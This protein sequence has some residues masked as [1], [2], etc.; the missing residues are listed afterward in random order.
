[1][2]ALPEELAELYRGLEDTLL[3]EICSRLRI[4]DQLNEV[5]V[6]DIRALRSHGIPLEDIKKAIAQ[7][8][9]ISMK[10]LDKLFDD[11]VARNQAYYTEL[12]DLAHVT[13]PE[14]L[15][16][17]AAIY[18]IYEQ[19]R[20]ELR[21]I[22]RSMGFMVRDGRGWRRLTPAKSYQW[23]L[24][25]AVM[26]VESGAISYNQA[27]SRAVKELAGGGLKIV[28]FESGVH[29]QI[30]SHARTCVM[31][32]VNQLNQKYREQSMDYLGTDL[33]EVT[34]HIGARNTGSGYFNHESWQGG[35]YHWRKYGSK[36]RGKY[37]DF[38]EECGMGQGGGIGGW[39]CRHSYWPYLDGIME[40]THSKAELESMKAE[41]HKVTFEGKE[42]DGYTSTQQQ[43]RIEREIR[44]QKR[45]RDACKATG[46][47]EDTQAANIRLNRLNEKYR[48]FSKAAGLPEQRERTK[49]LYA[50]DASKAKAA[51]LKLKRDAEAPIREAIK[52][53]DYP[54]AI[55]PEKQARHM[56]AT[57][58][59]GRS[60]ITI[61]QEELQEIIN[62]KAA[63]GKIELTDS[64][65]W[66]KREIVDAGKE[67][68]YTIN[69]KGDIIK[70]NSMKIHYSKTGVH[71]VPFSGRWKK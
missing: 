5:T 2:D 17:H 9:D 7:T 46:L 48:E 55:N 10:K 65:T 20:G 56:A 67:I 13:A 26:E 31:T 44:K 61:S 12:I 43:R 64:L 47:K 42:Y 36:H 62:R 40:P 28:D 14:T 54:L 68:G 3:E 30:D 33:V 70:T 69:A 51:A 59:P 22:T 1:M 18:A 50:D 6:Q 60:V 25:R 58:M 41:N 45:V 38:E 32:G 63:D 11:V 16:D 71:A 53:G 57:A 37:P 19:T 29:R 49:V 35:R 27:I 23:A 34:A 8:N 39:N 52:R 4:A 15:V 21:N 24:D 66:T